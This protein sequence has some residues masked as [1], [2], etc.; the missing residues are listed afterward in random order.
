MHLGPQSE[1][2]Q[3][4]MLQGC[5]NVPHLQLLQMVLDTD[6]APAGGSEGRVQGLGTK[7]LLLLRRCATHPHSQM[8]PGAFAVR[9]QDGSCLN[10][11]LML[12]QRRALRLLP[13][14]S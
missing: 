13:N 6:R 5:L 9:Q 2:C 11:L 12:Q 10:D 4:H 14:S 3:M 7:A 1:C 8:L